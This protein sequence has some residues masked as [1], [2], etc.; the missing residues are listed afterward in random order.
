[1]QLE[2]QYNISQLHNKHP[3]IKF[4]QQSTIYIYAS[5]EQL[6][7]APW[8]LLFLIACG[9]I[10]SYILTIQ[11]VIGALL[12]VRGFELS[13]CKVRHALAGGQN[14][15]GT[16]TVLV[17]KQSSE[18]SNALNTEFHPIVLVPYAPPDAHI[19]RRHYVA[20]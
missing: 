17:T 13:D 12:C 16:S 4:A 5:S 1:M 9:S 18:V 3:S 19:S 7:A 14:Q 11:S 2:Y 6:F 8:L 10:I 15:V 20:A